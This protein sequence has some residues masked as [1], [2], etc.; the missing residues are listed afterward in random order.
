MLDARSITAIAAL[1]TT[2]AG[3]VEMRVQV[4]LMASRLDRIE[5]ELR[6]EGLVASRP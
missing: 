6:S 3:V 5:K 1:L 4:G 2:L